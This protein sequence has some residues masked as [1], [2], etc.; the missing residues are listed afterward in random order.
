MWRKVFAD[1]KYQAKKKL[2]FNKASKQRTGGGPFTEK[3]ITASEEI[4]I[5]AAGLEA[6]V[7]GI[8]NVPAFGSSPSARTPRNISGSECN[9][10]EA[11]SCHSSL[12]GPSMYTPVCTKTPRSRTPGKK[13]GSD[14]KLALLQVNFKS[15]HEFQRSL[16]STDWC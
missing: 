11:N 10:E 13:S 1:Q 6:C 9:E 2:S 16:D 8:Q 12:P 14:E 3:V 7:E 15:M 4:L 5:E